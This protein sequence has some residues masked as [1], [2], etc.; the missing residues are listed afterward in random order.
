M[1]N[2][3]GSLELEVVI[4]AN[5]PNMNAAS[6]SPKQT[7][8]RKSTLIE[9]PGVNRTSIPEWRKELSERVREVQERRAREAAK[10]VA[11]VNSQETEAG[12]T[13]PQ[14]ELL[15]H[16]DLPAMNPLVAAALKRI[17]RAYQSG[18]ETRNVRQVVATAVAYAPARE[19]NEPEV[20]E[21]IVTAQLPLDTASDPE[22]SR[23]SEE[24]PPVEKSHNL[25]VVP[26]IEEPIV[27]IHPSIPPTPRRLIVE[28][29]PSLN[30]LDSIS[31]SVRVDEID[32]RRPSAFRRFIC[33]LLDLL[34][35]ALLSAPIAF[36]IRATGTD[37]R[38]PKAIEVVAG[39]LIVVTFMYL[40]LTIALTGR[41]LAM[42]L[43]SLRVIDIKTGLIP[44][45]RQSVGRSVL[46]LLSLALAGIGVLVAL[47]S[48]E[49]Y[50]T[51]D[52]LT[53]TAVI[54]T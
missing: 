25:M 6:D 53:R 3:A 54:K 52:R 1:D 28:N 33:G 4:P 7:P 37:L 20:I 31:R 12:L 48:R 45:G 2:E 51:H 23:E 42:R 13:T 49:G 30:Y 50:A 5:Q 26:P 43:L 47:V 36:A 21:S 14:L 34:I 19:E 38:D 10:E 8:V 18:S 9:F 16:A 40:T 11:E 46:Y 35:C 29:D 22:P 27:E 17:E 44:T 32:S 41:T 24:A 39:S 15:P